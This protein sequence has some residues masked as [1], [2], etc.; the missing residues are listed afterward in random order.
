M[1]D[2]IAAISTSSGI[3]AISIIRV[4]GKDSIEIVN[5]ICNIDLLNKDSHTIN[6]AHIY[7]GDTM[8]DEVLI[9]IMKSPKTF[10]TED[11]VEINCHGGVAVTKK[12]LNLLLENGCRL[13]EPGE[14]T[15]RAFL[16]GR[17]DLLE[18]EGIMDML[19][20]K[21]E[22]ARKMAINNINGNL[23][24]KI[25]EIR[26]ELIQI[27]SNI[28]VNIDYPE[29]NDIPEVTNNQILE[30]IQDVQKKISDLINES[31][32][33]RIIKEGINTVIIGKPNV[34][35]SS[36]LNL[37]IDENKAIVTDVPGTTRDIVEGSI[38]LNEII[39][40]II[41]TAGIRKTDDIVENIGVEKSLKYID[42]ADLILYILNNNETM[43]SDEFELLNKIKQKNHIILINKIDLERKID[44]E[45]INDEYVEISVSNNSGIDK[46]KEKI[47]Q[48]YDIDKIRQSDYTYLSNINDVNI[49]KQNLKLI[50]NVTNDIRNNI[51][52]D[53]LETD[54]KNIWQNLGLIIGETYSEEFLDELFS[55]F[56]LGK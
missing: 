12:V 45:K 53:M 7:D 27:L 3:G 41:D 4:S 11:I 13:A 29:Y 10:T 31:N 43:S 22:S 26:E 8:V 24:K 42:K 18:A 56:C 16:N 50:N 34:G 46:L 48:M 21:N 47:Q 14:F 28:S 55:R 39:L 25:K 20:A 32:N 30:I 6:Y 15:K 54:I 36:L 19:N 5:K 23:S 33:G 52:I 1:E 49:L 17:I 35:K 44:L 2:C 38:N 51:P 40:N 37:L 9:T